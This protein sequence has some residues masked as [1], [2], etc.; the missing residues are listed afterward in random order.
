MPFVQRDSC[1][2]HKSFPTYIAEDKNRIPMD[3]VGGCS[4]THIDLYYDLCQISNKE[5]LFVFS[6]IDGVRVFFCKKKKLRF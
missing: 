2:K 3:F 6:F 4:A 5:Y 1:Y